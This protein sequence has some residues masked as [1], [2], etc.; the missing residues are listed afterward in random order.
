MFFELDDIKRRHSNYYDIYNVG[1]WVTAPDSTFR[2]NYARGFMVGVTATFLNEFVGTFTEG[3]RLLLR[4]F[5]PPNT[6]KQVG[7]FAKE[8]LKLE[9]FRLAL[10]TRSQYALTLGAT[11]IAARIALFRYINSGWQKPFAGFEYAFQRKIPGTMLIAFLT[12]PLGI[13]F[14]MTRMAYYADKTFPEE[15]QRGYKSY[16]NALRRIPFEEGPYY[17]FKNTSPLFIRNFFQTFTLFYT[18]D[19]LKDK[20]S[21]MW[22]IMDAPY[23]P[24]KVFL[25]SFATYIA[26]VFSYPWAVVVREAVDFWPKPKNG[27]SPFNNN[28]RKAGVWLWYHDFSSNLFPGFFNNYFWKQAPWMMTTLILADSLGIFSYW[29]IDQFSGPGTNSWE[30]IIS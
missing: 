19:F 10:R 5:E 4:N 26:C 21:W 11:D 2:W 3:W 15:L 28:Y 20:C 27:I 13:P 12:A 25:A 8:T 18:Y 1:G 7:I 17:L 23:F 6:F 24:S 9:N 30:D 14:E 29:C 16:F 22:R